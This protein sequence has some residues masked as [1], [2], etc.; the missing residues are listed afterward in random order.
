[1]KFQLPLGVKTLGRSK[2]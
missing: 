1:L 2:L